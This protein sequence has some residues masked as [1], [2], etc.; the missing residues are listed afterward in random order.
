MKAAGKLVKAAGVVAGLIWFPWV[1]WE[2]LKSFVLGRGDFK[3]GAEGG[4]MF[5]AGL[6]ALMALLAAAVFPVVHATWARLGGAPRPNGFWASVYLSGIVLSVF[7]QFVFRL[8]PVGAAVFGDIGAMIA[9][10]VLVCVIVQFVGVV[11]ASR[12]AT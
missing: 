3:L 4:F 10:W 5:V 12:T 8:P 11:L 1:L 7:T 2:A 9:S 6:W